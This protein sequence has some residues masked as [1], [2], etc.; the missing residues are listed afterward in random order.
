M[1][2]VIHD[3]RIFV[4]SILSSIGWLVFTVSFAVLL[5]NQPAFFG[6]KVAAFNALTAVHYLLAISGWITNAASIWYSVTSGRKSYMGTF[7]IIFLTVV[8]IVAGGV[9]NDYGR[10]A[11]SLTFNGQLLLPDS[12][13]A[14]MAGCLLYILFDLGKLIALFHRSK[15][16]SLSYT[17]KV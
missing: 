1:P 10:I 17:N 2:C 5:N 6:Q 9:V 3:M 11:Y 7:L 15:T 12:A 13:K 4:L 14:A 8:L 16:V